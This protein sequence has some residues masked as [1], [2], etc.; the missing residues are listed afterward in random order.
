MK[1][2]YL[3]HPHHTAHVSCS[4]DVDNAVE[5][6]QAQEDVADHCKRQVEVVV[7]SASVEHGLVAHFKAFISTPTD[8]SC[9]AG[10]IVDARVP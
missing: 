10:Q 3:N 1:E 7:F 5:G 8:G 2:V 4:F 6:S 9:L